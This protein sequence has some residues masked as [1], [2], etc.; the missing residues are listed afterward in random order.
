MER[1]PNLPNLRAG[2]DEETPKGRAGLFQ[3]DMS[4]NAHTQQGV[5]RQIEFLHPDLRSKTGSV[6][7][8]QSH[9]DCPSAQ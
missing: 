4:A 9:Q 1:N 5:F 8:V 7:M 3:R 6:E 2:V